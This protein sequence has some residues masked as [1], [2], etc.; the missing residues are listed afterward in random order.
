[1]PCRMMTSRKRQRPGGRKSEYNEERQDHNRAEN[2]RGEVLSLGKSGE[3]RVKAGAV[4][5]VCRDRCFGSAWTG[6]S[7]FAQDER[8]WW[9]GL[10]CSGVAWGFEAGGRLG[11]NGSMQA[12]GFSRKAGWSFRLRLHSGLRQRGR[13]LG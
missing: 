5:V 1:M 12:V 8:A 2:D 11:M 6:A 13:G 3:F 10:W 4:L 9:G 7:S